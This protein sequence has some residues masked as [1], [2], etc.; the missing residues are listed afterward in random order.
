MGEAGEGEFCGAMSNAPRAYCDLAE[1]REFVNGIVAL[2][3]AAAAV[4]LPLFEKEKP[5]QKEVVFMNRGTGQAAR[6]CAVAISVETAS[7]AP[8]SVLRKSGAYWSG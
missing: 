8:F 4:G 1:G 3:D 7:S 5:H 2:N 6:G